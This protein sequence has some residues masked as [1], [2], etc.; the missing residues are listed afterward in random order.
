MYWISNKNK[1]WSLM[2]EFHF[3]PFTTYLFQTRYLFTP[4]MYQV[5]SPDVIPSFTIFS[6]RLR[7]DWRLRPFPIWDSFNN[8]YRTQGFGLATNRQK[9]TISILAFEAKRLGLRP[10][11]NRKR[12]I[13]PR[14]IPPSWPKME[15]GSFYILYRH[16]NGHRRLSHFPN[17]L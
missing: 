14:T 8:Y 3:V 16:T 9:R 1:V 11:G 5:C 6:F 4:R 17:R 2:K 10:I 12:G 7:V 15:T 13:W